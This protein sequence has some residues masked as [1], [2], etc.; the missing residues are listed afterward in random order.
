MMF[1]SV[2]KLKNSTEKSYF[3]EKIDIYTK[4][5]EAACTIHKINIENGLQDECIDKLIEVGVIEG[6]DE[7]KELKRLLSKDT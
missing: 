6:S 1:Q 2:K 5:V 3:K 4:I 7:L